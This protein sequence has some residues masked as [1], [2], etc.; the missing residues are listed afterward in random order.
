[1]KNKTFKHYNVSDGLQSNEFNTGAFYK[2]TDGQL[3]F[4]GVSGVNAFYP[5]DIID[6]PNKPRVYISSIKLFDEPYK[7][8]SDYWMK[9][10]ISLP[11]F[12]NTLSFDFIAT[13]MTNSE[14]NQYAYMIEGVD[15]NWINNGNKR[16]ARYANLP[17]GNYILK[18]KASNSDGVWNE[19][20][21]VLYINITPPFW[22]TNWFYFMLFFIVSGFLGSIVLYVINRQKIKLKRELE[23]QH[24]LEIER[25]R[26]SRDL[27]D[28]VGAQLSYLITNIDW[29]LEHPDLINANESN[30]RLTTLSDTGK[31]AILTLRQTIWALNN[32][33]LSVEEF[34]DRFKQFAIKMLE[35][36]KNIHIH[37]NEEI[38]AKNM[39]S[40]GVALN[41][42]R[43]CQE[44]FNNCL[45][46]SK[47]QQIDIYFES[48]K[49]TLFIFE[50][51][52][53]GV[54][55][56]VLNGEKNG[57]YGLQNMKARAK[58]SG[59]ELQFQSTI[60]EGT[61]IRLTYIHS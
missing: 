48:N 34:A 36:D 50:I 39:L 45:K 52:D 31:Q 30:K 4:G 19:T 54:G 7:C 58:E 38:D 21:T 18:I 26:I 25:L 5:R 13:E 40:P 27:H 42:F 60:N 8:D 59:A 37:F 55:F 49:N 11:Y 61:T 43:V 41:L 53:D 15:E 14:K 10:N 29:M 16:F 22:K 1:V 23:I 57:H 56:D 6:N 20:P 3:F 51:K 28:H 44:A 17:H 32:K 35:F 9:K 2:A 24:K 33:E 46:H 12:Q 47:C